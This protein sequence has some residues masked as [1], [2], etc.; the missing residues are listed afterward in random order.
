M[1]TKY[2]DSVDKIQ[3]QGVLWLQAAQE[4][5]RVLKMLG[6][7]LQFNKGIMDI[8]ASAHFSTPQNLVGSDL[9]ESAVGQLN[10]VTDELQ[11]TY[12]T[13][14]P[15]EGAIPAKLLIEQPAITAG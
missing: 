6:Q 7:P 4:T 5:Q 14:Q 3:D 11:E 15:S 13:G 2:L 10:Q 1:E 12:K 9:V 8:F